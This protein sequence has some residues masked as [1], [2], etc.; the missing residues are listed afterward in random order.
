MRCRAYRENP[1]DAVF[2]RPPPTVRV[3]KATASFAAILAIVFTIGLPAGQAALPLAGWHLLGALAYLPWSL[4]VTAL[5]QPRYRS[6][7]LAAVLDCGSRLL[8]SRAAVVAATAANGA[9]PQQLK[10]KISDD[11]TRARA[12]CR[13][14]PSGSA[15][16]K[17]TST[18][19]SGCCVA[20]PNCCPCHA[21]SC[22]S[23]SAPTAGRWRP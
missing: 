12:C 8:R 23:S 10:A 22:D 15:T 20:A 17:P 16:W 11:A 9:T 3:A 7:A 14:S 18:G 6:L 1:C 13:L 2:Q 21:D 19:S 5:L 4:A